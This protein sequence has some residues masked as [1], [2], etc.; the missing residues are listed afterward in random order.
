MIPWVVAG[1][2]G[3][4]IIIRSRP[5]PVAVPVRVTERRSRPRAGR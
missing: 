4:I 5:A 3:L 2:I 1:L